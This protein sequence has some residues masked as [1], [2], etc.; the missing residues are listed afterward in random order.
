MTIC[1][2]C[3]AVGDQEDLKKHT[4]LKPAKGKIKQPT[5]TLEA[6]Q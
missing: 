5:A 4:C 2:K 1:T 6:V 3:G